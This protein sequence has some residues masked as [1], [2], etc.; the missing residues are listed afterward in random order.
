MSPPRI[1]IVNDEHS[2]RDLFRFNLE[3]RGYEVSAL[4]SKDKILSLM[5]EYKPDTVILDL[6]LIYADGFELCRR[7][8]MRKN[9]SV[10]AFNMRGGESDLLKC[11]QLGVDDYIGKPF[12]VD[13]LMA[14][15]RAVLRS[16][17][18]DESDV[19]EKSIL[20]SEK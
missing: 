14:R 4:D 17:R 13:E 11:L 12:G 8:C 5:D 18:F 19:T 2:L 1:L 10:I 9:A 6:N 16:R 15:V 7:I 20:R 3:A